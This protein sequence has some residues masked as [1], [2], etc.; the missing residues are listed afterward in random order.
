MVLARHKDT[1]ELVALKVSFLDGPEA[2]AEHVDILLREAEYLAQLRHPNIVAG[3]IRNAKQMVIVMEWLRGGQVINRL[4]ELGP[5]Y[6][7]QTA[8]DLFSQV[9]EAMVHM[10]EKGVLHRDLKPENVLFQEP[11]ALPGVMPMPVGLTVA[12]LQQRTGVVTAAPRVKVLD[13][14]MACDY[15]PGALPATGAL[16]SA[17]FVAPEVVRGEAHTPAMDVFSMGVLLFVMLVG[18]KPFNIRQTERLQYAFMRLAEAPW[19]QDPR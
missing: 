6:T 18:R 2:D 4:H 14:R 10:H 7:E 12:Q 19:F 1:Q 5:R 9:A 13:L 16:G 11:P 8:C 17:G 15:A 3:V